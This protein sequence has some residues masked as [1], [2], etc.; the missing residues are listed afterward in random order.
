[1]NT[2]PKNWLVPRCRE[3]IDLLNYYNPDAAFMLELMYKDTDDGRVKPLYDHIGVLE[4]EIW[5]WVLKP[6]MC[7]LLT[8]DEFKEKIYDPF[9]FDFDLP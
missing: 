5:P 1:M 4:G 2:L 9:V 8:I 7:E 6:P 3:A